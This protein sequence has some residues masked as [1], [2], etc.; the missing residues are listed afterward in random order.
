MPGLDYMIY[1]I[2]VPFHSALFAVIWVH[3]LTEDRNLFSWWPGVAMK[4]SK[5]PSWHKIAFECE[6]CLAGQIAFWWSI[7]LS[8]PAFDWYSVKFII[9]QTIYAITIAWICSIIIS[10]IDA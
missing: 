10:K 4:I 2:D 5:H 6:K 1:M 3:V 8:W 9:L 7:I